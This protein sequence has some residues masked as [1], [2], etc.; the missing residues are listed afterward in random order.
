LYH[1]AIITTAIGDALSQSGKNYT[2]SREHMT[3]L[4]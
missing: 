3:F 2:L 1:I 4:I